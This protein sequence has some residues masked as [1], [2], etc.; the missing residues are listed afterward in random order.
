MK[1]TLVSL[2][3][4]FIVAFA[5]AQTLPPDLSWT[6]QWEN[7]SYGLVF[8]NTNLTTSVRSAIR[9]DIQ[10]VYSYNPS[11]NIAYR[12]YQPEDTDKYG[13]YT[14]H[15]HLRENWTCPSGLSGWDYKIY[16]GINYF[17]IGAEVSAN[18]I[19]KIAL[20]NQYHTEIA[21]LSNFLHT[22]NNLT[23]NNITLT[24]FQQMWW[25]LATDT[26]YFPEEPN[27]DH[28]ATLLRETS[29]MRF[30]YPS[31]LAFEERTDIQGNPLLILS[32]KTVKKDSLQN[33]VEAV[34]FFRAGQWRFMPLG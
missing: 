26:V 29:E 10:Q 19:A 33:Y 27:P 34:F 21:N 9:D 31:I 11:S 4:V 15:M 5:Q 3:A 24:A 12:I 1:H 7:A 8:E 14:G 2:C 28:W 30:P 25:S 16:G 17:F 32:I 13:K 23:T 6:F 18:Y 22:V 20:T